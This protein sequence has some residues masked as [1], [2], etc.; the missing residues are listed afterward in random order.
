ME[1]EHSDT[2]QQEIINI[3]DEEPDDR[4]VH[5]F[6]DPEG[7]VCKTSLAEQL[8]IE[9]KNCLYLTGKSEDM[10]FKVMKWINSGKKLKTVIIDYTRLAEG[11]VSYDG[12]EAIK[13]GI[14]FSTKYKCG[15]VG[16]DCPHVIVMADFMPDMSMMSQDRW[17][18]H[19]YSD[20]R[21]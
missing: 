20:D 12:I 4:T 8:C 9:L 13:D 3:V 10:K 1:E 19:D 2:A 5:W 18:I 6:Y 21:L 7:N 11:H 17:R 15:M 14:F 16:Y